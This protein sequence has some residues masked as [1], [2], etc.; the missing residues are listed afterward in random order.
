[1]YA[2]MRVSYQLNINGAYTR[3]IQAKIGLRQGELI[4]PLL[5]VIVMEDLHRKLDDLSDIP[6]LTTI[7]SVKS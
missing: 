5:F 1:M 7:V 3:E 6:N 4:S 2:A